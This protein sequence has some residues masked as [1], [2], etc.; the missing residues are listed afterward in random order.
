MLE[1]RPNTRLLWIA[2]M[3]VGS[4]GYGVLVKKDPDVA[5][6][7]M[8]GYIGLVLTIFVFVSLWRKDDRP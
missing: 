8:L 7:G 4:A 3:I 5:Q 2:I 1:M 6:A